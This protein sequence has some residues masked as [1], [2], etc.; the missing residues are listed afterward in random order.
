MLPVP[1]SSSVFATLSSGPTHALRS[2]VN[3][4]VLVGDV[5]S[6]HVSRMRVKQLRTGLVTPSMAFSVAFLSLRAVPNVLQSAAHTSRSLQSAPSSLYSAVYSKKVPWLKMHG[7]ISALLL[8]PSYI[9]FM[10][11]PIDLA[12]FLLALA[13]A[14][15][16][17]AS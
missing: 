12:V 14:P 3:S 6:S 8:T 15:L 17:R 1:L 7:A 13:L 5:V 11:S 9:Q 10:Y 4:C 16:L 2:A